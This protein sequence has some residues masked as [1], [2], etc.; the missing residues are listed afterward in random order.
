MGAIS[1][2]SVSKASSNGM[3]GYSTLHKHLLSTPGALRE[4]LPAY[5]LCR[6]TTESMSDCRV[7]FSIMALA[8]RSTIISTRSGD[9]RVA[10]RRDLDGTLGGLP[11]LSPGDTGRCGRGRRGMWKRDE[12]VLSWYVNVEVSES[13]LSLMCAGCGAVIHGSRSSCSK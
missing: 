2:L 12:V 5:M 8:M 10:L 7:S 13:K 11:L 6:C 4:A 3:A 1:I 9:V